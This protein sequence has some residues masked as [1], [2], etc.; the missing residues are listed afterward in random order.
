MERINFKDNAFFLFKNMEI[1]TK[2]SNKV[3][4]THSR[5]IG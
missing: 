3:R 2:L 4:V 5:F 1:A